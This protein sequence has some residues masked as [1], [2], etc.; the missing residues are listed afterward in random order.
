[1][2]KSNRTWPNAASSTTGV[3]YW[4]A[5]TTFDVP[6]AMIGSM[7]TVP[8]PQAAGSTPAE[9]QVLRDA[10]FFDD[11]IE[12]QMHAYRGRVWARI[13]AQ[14]YNDI[15][16]IDR[17]AEAV[18]TRV[19]AGATGHKIPSRQRAVMGT[20]G[21]WRGRG[22]SNGHCAPTTRVGHAVGRRRAQQ[23]RRREAP[24]T[25]TVRESDSASA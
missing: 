4:R 7:A 9:A 16:D 21:V 1:M 15:N 5:L 24:P 10:L 23:S 20:T 11:A 2:L 8:L 12:V 25:N 6:E 17:L 18:A 13:S 14:I 19:G 22:V 3:P